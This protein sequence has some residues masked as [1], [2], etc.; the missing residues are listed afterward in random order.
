MSVDPINIHPSSSV[1]IMP[2]VEVPEQSL[3][4]GLVGTELPTTR[5]RP[6][7]LSSS[8]SSEKLD[9]SG[10]DDADWNDVHFALDTS[11]YYHLGEEEV[12]VAAPGIELLS[13]K[14]STIE[15]I[16]PSSIITPFFSPVINNV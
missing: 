13:V 9:Y 2:S 11:K 15:G 7:L 10:D 3:V 1:E 5:V 8:S 14:T 12:Q 6:T 4:A 16:L